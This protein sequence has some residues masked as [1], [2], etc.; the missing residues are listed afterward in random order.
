MEC[1]PFSDLR[2][3]TLSIPLCEWLTKKKKK[4]KK[5]SAEPNTPTKQYNLRS[6]PLVLPSRPPRGVESVLPCLGTG[7]SLWGSDAV[8]SVVFRRCVPA[9]LLGPLGLWWGSMGPLCCL[10][11][12]LDLWLWGAFGQ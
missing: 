2:I 1:L 10:R 11:W 12:G 7:G 8:C 4:S 9:R 5:D 3:F 6:R